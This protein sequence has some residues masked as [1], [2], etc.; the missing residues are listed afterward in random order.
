MF[1]RKNRNR[2][3]SISVQ[4]VQKHGRQNK[5]LKNVGIAQTER[6]LKL[7]LII[8]KD[9]MTKMQGLQSLFVEEEDLIIESFVDGLD[10]NQLQIIGPQL[11]LGAIYNSIGFPLEQDDKYFKHLVLSRLVYPGSKL[12][13][14]KYLKRHYNLDVSV[15]TLYLY[16]DELDASKRENIQH[17]TF[18]HTSKVL[19][20][21]IGVIFYDM[22]TLYFEAS[23]EDDLRKIGYSKD[24]KHQHP[25]IMLGLLVGRNGYPLSYEIFEGNKSETKTLIPVL[26]AFEGRFKIKKPIVVA[27]CALLSKKNILALKTEGYKYIIGGKIKNEPQEIKDQILC[28]DVNKK[29]P[30]EIKNQHGRLIV[31][32]SSK[33]AKKDKFNRQR[34][35][36]RLEAKIKSGKM[37]K[38]NLNN[39]GY[40]KYLVLEGEMQVKI[41]YSKF[42]AD[43]VWDGLKGYSTNTRISKEKV[44]ETY[45]N[46]W[47]I[48]KA[49]R[50][51][52]T[53]LRIRPIYHRITDRI[54][55][56][57][58]ICFAAYSVY[59]E[60]ERRL[61]QYKM[62][63]TPEKA[64]DLVKDIQQLTYQL[65]KSKKIKTK[66]F[67]L[68]EIQQ[69]LLEVANF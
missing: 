56:H 35:L 18:N 43:Q 60:L 1:I 39:R 69:K 49:F 15:H 22:T 6:D 45:S 44:I 23:D 12:K 4:I 47:L 64:I 63:I 16:L 7:L 31:S 32:F 59:K 21:K 13:T 62:P 28:L 52:K 57:I 5:I 19:R 51:S 24:G 10:N 54:E 27:D 38:E 25:Q 46:L 67:N 65:P 30:K 37:K 20:G 3:G 50:I 8:A 36:K 26:K 34:G 41:D 29:S 14:T 61:Y 11:I 68:D 17:I 9:K 53:D 42:N 40:N 48:E 66:I 58:C 55:A 33:R 2:S